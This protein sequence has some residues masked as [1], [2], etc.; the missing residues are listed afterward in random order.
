MMLQVARVGFRKAISTPGWGGDK[1]REYVETKDATIQ[2]DL[3]AR[4][5]YV[6]PM[7]GDAQCV[8]LENVTQWTPEPEPAKTK[9]SK[10]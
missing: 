7:R 4:V 8:P 10:L 6:R 1:S 9:T 5:C 3:D 2:I